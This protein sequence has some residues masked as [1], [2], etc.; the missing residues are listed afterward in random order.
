MNRIIGDDGSTQ[1]AGTFTDSARQEVCSFRLLS[2]GHLHCAPV[3][4]QTSI[5]ADS[6]CTV[7]VLAAVAACGPD[8]SYMWVATDA[9]TGA[10]RL[11]K[12]AGKLAPPSMV[13]QFFAGTCIGN[14]T[15]PTFDYYSSGPELAPSLFVGG[16]VASE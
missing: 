8:A 2:D 1:F 14:G 7:P 4:R 16:T 6:S 15:T 13:Y 10:A 12:I 5:Y 3:A 11:F 9:C